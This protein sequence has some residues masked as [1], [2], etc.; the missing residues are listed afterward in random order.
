LSGQIK[1]IAC[2]EDPEII[3]KTLEHLKSNG[4]QEIGKLPQV[5]AY[6]SYEL[7]KEST[8]KQG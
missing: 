1:A 2:I 8:T 4:E 3:K 7:G 6:L 5:R